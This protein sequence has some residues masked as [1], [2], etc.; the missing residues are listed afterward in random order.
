MSM[1]VIPAIDIQDGSVVRLRQGKFTEVTRYDDDPLKV[2]QGWVKQGASCLHIVDLDGART[3]QMI[4]Y[5]IIKKLAE[6]IS[7]PIQVGGGIRTLRDIMLL[8]DA[9]IKRVILGTKAVE[10]KAFLKEA[11]TRWPDSIAV[12]VDCSDGMVS[13]RGWTELS[14]LPTLPF[15]KDLETLGLKYLVYTDIKRDGMLTGPDLETLKE[16][17]ANVNI[18]VIASGG[19]SKIKDIADLMDLKAKNLYG[20]ISGKALYEQTLDFKEAIRLCSQKG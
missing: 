1:H 11:I 17:L 20:V 15:C 16:I 18:N 8:L 3:H 7:V 5:P 13:L 4:N 12:S 6:N 10:D 9:G 19:V 14:G 2:A